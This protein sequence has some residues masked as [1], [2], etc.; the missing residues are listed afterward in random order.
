MFEAAQDVEC[1]QM[2]IV[3]L[4]ALSAAALPPFTKAADAPL[5]D[6]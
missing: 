5:L 3:A 6:A 2:G 1:A 4:L